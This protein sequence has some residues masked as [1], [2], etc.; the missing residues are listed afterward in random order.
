LEVQ[1][2]IAAELVGALNLKGRRGSTRREMKLRA[3]GASGAGEG[4]DVLIRNLSTTGM[5]LEAAVGLAVGQKIV[6]D[7]PQIGHASAEIVWAGDNLFGCAFERPLSDAAVSAAQLR[8]EPQAHSNE[9]PLSAAANASLTPQTL[10]QNIRRLRLARGLSLVDFA[11]KMQV[12]RPTVW[13]W[14]AGKSAPRA[15]K[16]QL[17]MKVLEIGERELDDV[18]DQDDVAGPSVSDN[19]S[20]ES[21]NDD[22]KLKSIVSQAKA[23]I[24]AAAGTTPDKITLILEI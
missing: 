14:E 4:T 19:P 15:R 20:A 1:V 23:D 18:R 6:I 3:R 2:A 8:S 9:A 7:L 5:L 16:R 17:L 22:G 12:S 24:A 11:Q 13:S 21:L 10:G